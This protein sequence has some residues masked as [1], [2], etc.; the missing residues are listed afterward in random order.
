MT[1]IITYTV[2]PNQPKK[3]IH[4]YGDKNIIGVILKA[5]SARRSPHFDGWLLDPSKEDELNAIIVKLGGD[6]SKQRV[7]DLSNG[8]LQTELK[9]EPIAQ[10]E[11]ARGRRNRIDEES[12]P[13]GRSP[14]GF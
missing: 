14:L 2:F 10:P 11:Q 9:I 1:D 6:P 13:R 7:V 5:M 8:Q 12:R 3:K 4:V